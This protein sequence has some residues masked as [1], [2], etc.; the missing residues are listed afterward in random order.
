MFQFLIACLGV[1]GDRQ[2]KLRKIGTPGVPV[3]TPPLLRWRTSPPPRLARF[4][5]KQGLVRD[6][7]P[8]KCS[9]NI[10]LEVL[11]SGTKCGVWNEAEGAKIAILQS[12]HS[13]ASLHRYY[14]G[15]LSWRQYAYNH[16]YTYILH[17]T[18]K[19]K[20]APHFSKVLALRHALQSKSIKWVLFVDLDTFVTNKS[21]LLEHIIA[22]APIQTWLILQHEEIIC[23]CMHI[24]RNCP[25]STQFVDN[26]LQLGSNGCCNSH[27]Y[28]QRA[29]WSLLQGSFTATIQNRWQIYSKA[30]RKKTLPGVFLTKLSL[31][32][33]PWN[34]ITHAFFRHTGHEN[35]DK[36]T[37]ANLLQF[38][39]RADFQLDHKN[40]TGHRGQL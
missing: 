24:W 17:V 18:G 14:A 36:E 25:Q 34:T 15:I 32:S 28:D 21:L 35:W 23:S 8:D 13:A 4:G 33:A 16:N 10:S 37:N 39:T 38:K 7:I 3:N 26:W 20:A 11:L 22:S 12:A 2:G 1:F 27:S 9:Q 6:I 40:Q 30:I 31:H 19:T 29:F 5:D